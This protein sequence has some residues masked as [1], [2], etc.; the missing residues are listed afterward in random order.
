M[1]QKHPSL[2]K[3]NKIESIHVHSGTFQ[4]SEPFHSFNSDSDF[5]TKLYPRSFQG[6][7]PSTEQG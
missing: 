6:T 4:R 3:Y 7:L 5:E 1:K 2:Q